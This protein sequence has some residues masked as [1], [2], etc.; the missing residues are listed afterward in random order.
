MYLAYNFVIFLI[1]LISVIHFTLK[2]LIHLLFLAMVQVQQHH[3]T[4]IPIQLVDIIHPV[5]TVS[6]WED[7]IDLTA[8]LSMD[9]MVPALLVD[10]PVQSVV[11][12]L[13]EDIRDP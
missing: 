4:R 6:L 1:L 5:A 2:F 10:I 12:P 11:H 13:L 7:I 9:I 3:I 8:S